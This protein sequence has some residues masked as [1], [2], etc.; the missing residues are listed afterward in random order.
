MIPGLA[1]AL[2]GRK[3]FVD[4]TAEAAESVG[5]GLTGDL[6]TAGS[7]FQGYVFIDKSPTGLIGLINQGATCYLN[8]F[9]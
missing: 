5:T 2:A 9:L 7:R 4:E 3:K 8:S 1:A 6:R